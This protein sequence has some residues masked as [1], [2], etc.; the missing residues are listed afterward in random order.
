MTK[1]KK[2]TT[3]VQISQE[4][5][6]QAQD[7]LHTYH[8]I[9]INLHE[10]SSQVQIETV[11]AEINN[12]PEGTQIAFL[13]SLSKEHHTDA[14]DVLI[15]FNELSPLKNVRKE[16]KRSLI[17]LQGLRVYPQWNPPIDLRQELQVTVS[18]LRF[19]KGVVTDS[20]D[21]GEV[22]LALGFEYEDNP[23]QVR[24]LMFLLEF[25]HDGIKD[26]LTRTGNKRSVENFIADME[27]QLTD[28]ETKDC[29]LA[30]ARR[31]ILEALDV[32][33]RNGT[34]PHKDYRL[35][36]SLVNQLILDYPGLED[37]DFEDEVELEEDD[38]DEIDLH[39]LSPSAV[40]VN[41]VEHWV[42]G[43]FEVAYELL[44]VNSTLRENLPIDGWIERRIAWSDEVDPRGLIPDFIHELEPQEPRI[45]LPGLASARRSTTYKEFEVG[46]SVELE[47]TPV[48]YTLPE[49]PK[50]IAVYQETQRHWFWTS[51][52]LVQ[53]E[54]EWRIQSIT[55]EAE[56][57]QT[58]SIGELRKRVLKHD[59]YLNKHTSKHKS[60][61]LELE[62]VQQYLEPIIWQVMR[63]V[64]YTE[65]LIKKIP[66]DYDLYR[67]V[68]TRLLAIFQYEHGLI[69]LEQL[70]QQFPDG[71]RLRQLSAFYREVSKRLFEEGDDE[72]SQH[73]L[74]LAAE[75]LHKS[76]GLED[77]FEAHISLAE[78]FID[79][80]E[81]LDEAEDHLY[82]AKAMV[83]DPE[84]VAHI[85]LHLGEIAFAQKRYESAL[86]H[87]QY[88]ADFHSSSSES[89][90]SVAMVYKMLERYDEAETNY[91]RA[92]ELD[93]DNENNYITLSEMFAANGDSRKAIEV[94][95]EGLIEIPDSALLHMF[96]AM[97]FLDID[98]VRQAELFLKKA[99][100]LEPEGLMGQM[101]GQAIDV[102]KQDRTSGIF[103][104][105][106]KLSKPENKKRTR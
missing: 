38:E 43:N 22:N 31:L 54:N 67:D 100:R 68:F 20:R 33:K 92:I 49:V 81:H 69:Y 80:E 72:R 85:E 91:R 97:R 11:I 52:T 1:N 18:P 4:N 94:L 27:A 83:T 14:A 78:V 7:V 8:E 39:G 9:A 21:V 90:A 40:V 73:F 50:P 96:L 101:I 99:E 17:V 28:V 23:N 2:K 13:K 3:Q 48:T 19:W 25:Y 86:E 12:L 103:K 77:S 61:N 46:W 36:S 37:D 6:A 76:L 10:S 57:A 70:A 26:F 56:I 98:D 71:T 106:L 75:A 44:A 64:Y 93:P 105:N 84:E 41:F 58:L 32:N 62:D 42:D 65:T 87:Y 60:K 5:A 102:I 53:E 74:D 104:P 15:A 30:Q 34:Q 55:D 47:E 24:V 51:F 82:Q 59:K 63:S 66:L 89:W 79:A 45:W 88:V 95:E 16:A 35:N 29:T